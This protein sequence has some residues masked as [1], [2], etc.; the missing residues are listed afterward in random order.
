MRLPSWLV[1]RTLGSVAYPLA[2]LL[3]IGA[4]GTGSGV[5]AD[6]AVGAAEDAQQPL[7]TPTASIATADVTA[8]AE[9]DGPPVWMAHARLA[10]GPRQ[11]AAVVALGGEIVVLGGFDGGG[12]IVATVEA[13]E[14]SADR[15]RRLADLP[16]PMHHANAAV[17]DGRIYVVGFLTGQFVPSGRVFVYGPAADAWTERSPMPVGTQRGASGVA[18]VDGAIYL[19]GGLGSGGAV[20]HFSVYD[21]RNDA[22]QTLPAL[23][24]PRDHL[25]AGAIGRT[26]YVAGGRGGSIGSH[27]ARL[28][29]FELTSGRWSARAPMPTSRAGVAAAVLGGRLYVF[30]G[31]GNAE[32]PA[33]VFAAAEAY[34]PE[35]D[36]WEA[37][38]PMPTPRHGTGAAALGERIYV[39]GGATVLGFGA[40]DV[41]ESLGPVP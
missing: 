20:G 28:D 8:G 12:R 36:R 6:G 16:L 37:L 39:P 11:E 21:P 27:T 18:T 23:P 22:W 10:R 29:A 2:A 1:V 19:A 7:A 5:G 25:A 3:A 4:C 26:V 24:T 33:G 35:G 13:Y 41:S 15:W 9:R 14:P 34:D 30:G 31:E 17:V 38:P 32:D 40:V